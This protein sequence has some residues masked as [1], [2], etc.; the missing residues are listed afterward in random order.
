MNI[1]EW[2]DCLWDYI[3]DNF[4][5]SNN[6]LYLSFHKEILEL[7]SVSENSESGVIKENTIE[8]FNDECNSYLI[9]KKKLVSLDPEVWTKGERGLS[10][11]VCYAVQQILVAEDMSSQTFY[12]P[13]IQCLSA[14]SV[15]PIISRHENPLGS[16]FEL[17]WTTIRAELSCFLDCESEKITFSRGKGSNKLRNYPF[18]QS[19][20]SIKELI[21]LV[22]KWPEGTHISL[23]T[24]RKVILRHESCLSNRSLKKLS[25]FNYLVSISKQLYLYRKNNNPLLEKIKNVSTINKTQL[26][27][28]C[29]VGS[30]SPDVYRLQIINS[31]SERQPVNTNGEI[32]PF[33]VNDFIIFLSEYAGKWTS[34]KVSTQNISSFRSMIVGIKEGRKPDFIDVVAEQLKISPFV[35]DLFEK[36]TGDNNIIFYEFPLYELKVTDLSLEEL[37]LN[38]PMKLKSNIL[39]FEGGLLVDKRKHRYH[40]NY[41]PVCLKYNGIDLKSDNELSVDGLNVTVKEFFNNIFSLTR[42]SNFHITFNGVNRNIGFEISKLDLAPKRPH[43]KISAGEICFSKD[44]IINLED[45]SYFSHFNIYNYKFDS[46]LVLNNNQLLMYSHIPFSDWVDIPRDELLELQIFESLRKADVHSWL[47]DFILQIN[48]SKRIPRP[49]LLEFESHFEYQCNPSSK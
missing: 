21:K 43:L 40:L 24:C 13:Y 16:D 39:E 29:V 5:S 23:E 37:F 28:L 12:E 31:Q 30:F 15:I 42:E 7:I 2:R 41:P 32:E 38:S 47:Y 14:N 9:Y 46:Y 35:I 34:S 48:I 3:R 44:F 45:E 49:F 33:L 1:Y 6:L 25:N 11:A 8:L 26:E 36:N 18:T 10:L 20:L 22:R 17:I 4:Y 27:I 19:L